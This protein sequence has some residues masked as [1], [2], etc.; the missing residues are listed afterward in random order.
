MGIVDNLRG[1]THQLPMQ[2]GEFW[3][4][5]VIF[6]G[7]F[8]ALIL[9]GTT[10]LRKKENFNQRL[11]LF[12]LLLFAGLYQIVYSGARMNPDFSVFQPVFVNVL[13]TYSI[14]QIGPLHYFYFAETLEENRLNT[15]RRA[16]EIAAILIL[17]LVIIGLELALGSQPDAALRFSGMLSV[18]IYF[19]LQVFLAYRIQNLFRFRPAGKKRFLLVVFLLSAMILGLTLLWAIAWTEFLET[20]PIIH[21]GVTIY[22]IALFLFSQRYPRFLLIT[23]I[24]LERDRYR[25]SGLYEI[26]I[27]RTIEKIRNL[28]EDEKL[29]AM[30]DLTLTQLASEVEITPHQLSELLNSRLNRSFNNFVNEYRIREAAVLLLEEKDRSALSIGI[31]VGFNSNSAFYK[32]FRMFQGVSPAHFRKVKSGCQS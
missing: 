17:P 1:V 25:K 3:L 6:H 7:G 24:E 11:I 12:L 5:Q 19:L 29:Y 21:V 32:A 10:I 30:E 14:F 18:L 23:R 20:R 9:A 2:G 22:I 13:L 28:M 27:S 8:F 31:A 4:N 16:L 26:D 15:R